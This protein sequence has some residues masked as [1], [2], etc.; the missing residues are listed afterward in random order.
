MKIYAKQV[1]PEYQE[2]PLHTFDEYPEDIILDGN[3]HYKSHTTPLYDRI[4]ASYD[5][6]AEYLDELKIYGKRA[7]YRNVTEIINDYFPAYENREKP[8]STK[9]IHNIRRA[10]ELYGSR[11]YYEGEYIIAMLNAI[12][13][14]VWRSGTIRGCCQGDWQDIIYLAESWSAAALDAFETEYFNTGTEW[15]VHDDENA[16]ETPDDISG[17]SVYCTG[18]RKDDIRAEIAD[19]AG[20]N[21]D[22]V[23]LYEFTGWSR[24]A[25]WEEK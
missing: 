11:D 12:T 4:L 8:Y 16:P 2:S 25:V 14:R 20:G 21:A 3:R 6:A 1:P 15:I 10:L 24:S 9:D 17:F 22:D 7:T 23:V 13:G 19:A 18:W 5:D